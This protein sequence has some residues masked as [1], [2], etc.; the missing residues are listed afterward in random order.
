MEELAERLEAGNATG[1]PAQHPKLGVPP[2]SHPSQFE[3]QPGTL[4]GRLRPCGAVHW[5]FSAVCVRRR[6]DPQDKLPRTLPLEKE[7]FRQAL[8]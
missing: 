2:T 1:E 4:V 8:E 5:T 6:G 3:P 7:T